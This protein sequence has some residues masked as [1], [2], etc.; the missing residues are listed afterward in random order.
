MRCRTLTLIAA[1]GSAALLGGAWVFQW[2]GYAPC[3]MCYWQRWPHMAAVVIAVAA[4]FVPVTWLLWAGALAVAITGGIGVFHA[5][6]EQGWWPGPAS[7]TQAGGGLGGLSGGDLL[8]LDGPRLILCDQIAWSFMGLSMAAWNAVFSFLLVVV[9]L[10]AARAP[11]QGG[12]S[13]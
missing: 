2:L 11:G 1:L 13:S 4:L 5:G 3:K 6:V 8:A 7:C 12:A 9:W 10:R